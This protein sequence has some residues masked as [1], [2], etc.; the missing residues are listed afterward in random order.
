ML[1]LVFELDGGYYSA[2]T[3]FGAVRK[4]GLDYKW[5]NEDRANK[6]Y[7]DL[8]RRLKNSVP[9]D[10]RDIYQIH[11]DVLRDTVYTEYRRVS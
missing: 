10:I 1:T 5:R 6:G 7:T 9:L 8:V 11:G 2:D 4:L 3:S